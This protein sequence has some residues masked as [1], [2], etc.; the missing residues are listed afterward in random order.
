MPIKNKHKYSI[1]SAAILIVI[2]FSFVSFRSKINVYADSQKSENSLMKSDQEKADLN[3]KKEL[4]IL[5]AGDIMLD[6]YIRKQINKYATREEFISKFLGNIQGVNSKYDY[7]MANL[8]G[9]IT[10]N[11]SKSLNDDGSYGKDLIFTFPI[12]SAQILKLLNIKIVSLANNHTDNFYHDGYMQTKKYLSESEIKYFGNPYNSN[13][14]KESLSEIVCEK[15]I[16]VAY[17]GYHQ[18]TENNSQEIVPFYV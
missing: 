12:S 2:A 7:V 4:H 1:I 18:F 11:K 10:E 8:E 13:S 5:V 3:Q 14:A 9:P 17:I 15:D 6:R 16:C